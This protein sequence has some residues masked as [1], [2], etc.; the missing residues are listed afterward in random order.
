MQLAL[1]VHVKCVSALVLNHAADGPDG[2]RAV[3]KYAVPN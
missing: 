3:K 1:V 2:R